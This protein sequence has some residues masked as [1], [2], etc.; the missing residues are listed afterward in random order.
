M[1]K[2]Y[3]FILCFAALGL[4]FTGCSKEDQET[5]SYS[6]SLVDAP[7][8][9]QEVNVDIQGLEVIVNGEIIKLDV[10][11]Q[12]INLLELTGGVSALLADGE[13]PVGQINQIRLILGDNNTLVLE[14]ETESE[15]FDL[16]TPSAQQTGLKLVVAKSLEAGIQYDFI[17]DFNVDKSVVNQG[18]ESGYSLKPVIRV[19]TKA[20]SGAIAGMVTAGEQTLVTAASATDT[21]SAYTNE[22][23]GAF[24]LY[25]VPAGEYKVTV[26]ETVANENVEVVT[27]E[28]T[29]LGQI[30]VQ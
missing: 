26:G 22:E 17:L 28:T 1:K 5:A 18:A 8:D 23:T 12:V 16:Q 6:F 24:L 29:D 14:G 4:V 19:T 11:P 13:L 20:E 27:G 2:I 15:V 10:E 9:Y 7:G 21:I 30:T 25:A 3:Q